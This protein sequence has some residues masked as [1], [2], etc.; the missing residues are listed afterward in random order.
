VIAASEG[1][2]QVAS[3]KG[4]VLIKSLQLEGR[5]SLPV[6][7]FLRGYSLQVESRLGE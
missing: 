6:A 4:V 7:D 5:R 1:G 2:L 3:G